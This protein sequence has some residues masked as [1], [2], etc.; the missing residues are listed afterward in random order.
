MSTFDSSRRLFL[1]GGSAALV[2]GWA[3]AN[4]PGV[5]AAL[6]HAGRA[7]ASPATLPFEFFTPGQGADVEAMTGR[8]WPADDAPGAVEARVVHFIDHAL[9]NDPAAALMKPVFIAGV[10]QL[11]TK[12]VELFPDAALGRFAGLPVE[13]QTQVLKAIEQT[14]FFDTVRTV[15][16]LGLLANPT[17]GANPEGKNWAAIGFEPRFVWR[18]PFGA[19]DQD[20]HAGEGE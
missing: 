17:Y 12:V 14:P 8:I 10:D 2:T 11:Q 7:A 19:Y 3:A 1:A 9:A 15:T 20:A 13:R 5:R 4:L 18:P 6:A 16:L